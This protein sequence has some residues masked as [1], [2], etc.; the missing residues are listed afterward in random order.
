M[1]DGPGL[2]SQCVDD[3]PP[4]GDDII[5]GGNPYRSLRA[6]SRIPFVG[7]SSIIG[8]HGDNGASS[9]LAAPAAN[10]APPSV[11]ADGAGDGAEEVRAGAAEADLHGLGG[12]E[13]QQQ[14]RPL[15]ATADD[16]A[17]CIAA[18]ERSRLSSVSRSAEQEEN[19]L[20]G[21]NSREEVGA[22]SGGKG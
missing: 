9:S 4:P 3:S 22:G 13:T 11:S 14:V 6:R 16:L 10:P 5:I 19:D 8:G 1:V 20:G 7:E 21:G 17:N 18:C 12:D 15:I 2:V